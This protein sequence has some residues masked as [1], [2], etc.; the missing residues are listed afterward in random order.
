LAKRG[1][2]GARPGARVKK[3][4]KREEMLADYMATKKYY[5]QAG[6]PS[7]RRPDWDS[8]N[9]HIAANDTAYP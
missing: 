5:R 4:N 1:L 9:Q 8:S 6:R 3:R 7:V 2:R